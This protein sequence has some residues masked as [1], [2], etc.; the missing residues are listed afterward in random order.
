ML[1]GNAG[2]IF[3]DSLMSKNLEIL[4]LSNAVK[5]RFQTPKRT[6]AHLRERDRLTLEAVMSKNRNKSRIEC[7]KTMITT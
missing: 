1:T 4:P 2:Q 6:R 3:F 7:L 5:E